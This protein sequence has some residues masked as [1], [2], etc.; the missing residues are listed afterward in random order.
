MN[1]MTF[2]LD[3]LKENRART[4]QSG[5]TKK[6]LPRP[7]RV[8]TTTEFY[9]QTIARAANRFN[10]A[11]YACSKYGPDSLNP[12]SGRLQKQGAK[13]AWVQLV[14]AVEKYNSTCKHENDM[15][16]VDSRSKVYAM[17]NLEGILA[18]LDKQGFI[19]P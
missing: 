2:V 8:V 19:K 5:K 9:F 16:L 3:R 18:K 12:I 7:Q 17:E 13:D 11:T 15:L 14:A 10:G 6:F 4:T 1:D